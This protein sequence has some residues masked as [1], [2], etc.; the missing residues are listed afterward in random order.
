MFNN[1]NNEL[2][3]NEAAAEE[4]VVAEVTEE[5]TPEVA[6]QAEETVSKKARKQ[7]SK[8]SKCRTVFSTALVLFVAVIVAINLILG[9]VAQR[10][11]LNIDLTPGKVL[12]F[13]DETKDLLKNLK[14]KVNIYSLSDPSGVEVL[15]TVDKILRKY[16]QLSGKIAYFNIDTIADPGFLNRYNKNGE[17]ISDLSVIFECGSKYK[18]V[19]LNDVVGMN[20]Y[21]GQAESLYA[22]Q[23]FNSAIMQ[24]TSDTSVNIGLVQGHDEIEFEE[25]HYA[26]LAPENYTAEPVNIL[27]RGIPETVDMLII[28]SPQ[29]DFDPVEIDRLD[30]YFDKGGKVQ[31]IM[32]GAA[33]DTPNLD[34]YLKEWGVTVY[35]NGYVYETDT[36]S[37]IGHPTSI[38]PTVVNSDAT[39]NI[40]GRNSMIVYQAASGITI[41]EAH[42]VEA[43]DLLVTSPGAYLKENSNFGGDDN[44][45]ETKGPFTLATLLTRANTEA[46]PRFM[47]MGGIGL[48]PAFNTATYA[49]QD[50]YYNMISYM[51]GDEDSMYIRPKDITPTIMAMPMAHVIVWAALTIIVL[52]LIILIAGLVIWGKRRHL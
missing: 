21:T 17:E 45:E 30:E 48:F 34:G 16:K 15:E 39:K 52:P 4:T 36:N 3:I 29:K 32:D 31:L 35:N 40:V 47:V 6:D 9:S 14:K 49:N 42:G 7:M 12:D 18:I 26:I 19:D 22:E 50:F 38:V 20:Q 41:E 43:I 8:Q 24:V 13:S 46:T 51:N 33:S 23:K 37:Y 27:T 28:A 25:F 2:N 44:A 10:V 1:E 5:V 11:N